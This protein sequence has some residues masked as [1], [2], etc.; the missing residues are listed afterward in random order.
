MVYI[1]GEE[2][3][4]YASDIFL[5]EW[6]RPYMDIKA[7]E[8]YDLSCVSR[9]KTNDQVLKDCIAAGK[10]IGAIYKEPTITPTADQ[11]Q[12][13]PPPRH[14]SSPSSSKVGSFEML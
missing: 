13:P 4:R 10:R 12:T 1:A 5:N 2:Y 8:T 3:S 9:D 14:L 7:W 6:I 11:V